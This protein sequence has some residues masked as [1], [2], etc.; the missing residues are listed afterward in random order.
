[1]SG[2]SYSDSSQSCAS[3]LASAGGNGTY[4]CPNTRR[5]TPE[6]SMS[7]PDRVLINV[8]SSVLEADGDKA[9]D[10]YLPI[11]KNDNLPQLFMRL[12]GSISRGQLTR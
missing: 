2:E 6:S 12:A 3:K 9:C 7:T 5:P 8:S 10:R 11:R 1:L 4:A